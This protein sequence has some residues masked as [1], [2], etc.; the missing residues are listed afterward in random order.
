MRLSNLK[1]NVNDLHGVGKNTSQL[2]SKLGIINIGELLTYF[3]RAYEDR[4]TKRSFNQLETGKAINTQITVTGKEFFG[5]GKKRTLKI[6]VTDDT[7]TASLV[8]FG[9]SFLD[10]QIHIDEQY[11]LYGQFTIKYGELQCSSFEL[12]P[13]TD[14]P[15]NFGKILPLYSLS[16]GLSQKTLRKLVKQA[17]DLY[18]KSLEEELPQ[19]ILSKNNLLNNSIALKYIHFPNNWQQYEQARNSLAYLEL[20]NIQ[21]KAALDRFNRRNLKQKAIKSKNKLQEQLIDSL[22]F[23]LTPDQSQAIQDINNDIST[24]HPMYRLIQGEVGSGKT[25]VAFL[26]ALNA[27]EQGYQVAFMAPTELLAKQHGENASQLLMPLG[28]RIAFMS[29]KLKIKQRSILLEKLKSGEIDLLIGTHALFSSDVQFKSLRLVIVDE[30]HR[31]GVEQRKELAAKGHNP[32]VLL[33]TATPIPRS[34]AL[35]A[36][37]NLDISTIQTMPMGRKRIETHLSKQDSEQKVYDFIKKEL[38]SGH[39][40]YFVYPLIDQS[41]KLD[42]LDAESM[43]IKLQSEFAP[44]HCGLIHSKIQEDLKTQTMKEF[45]ENKIQIL[46]ATSVV[47]VGVDVPNATCIV[48]VHA[49]RFGLSTLHQLRGRVGRS[50]LQSYA[51]L[52]YSTP[53]SEEAKQRLKIMKETNDG[54]RISQ[55]DMAIRGPGDIT[56]VRQSGFMNFVI[57]DITVDGD[58]LIKARDDAN[59]I[60]KEDPDLENPD[61]YCLKWIQ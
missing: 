22:P 49:E 36:F 45:Q 24:P 42:L 35:T 7:G 27:I 31:F 59:S 34:L 5:F 38:A 55:E 15:K 16:E 51:F 46:V 57:A 29:G 17:L 1:I 53:L 21:L 6:F 37:G 8:C 25:L 60:I 14:K 23:S 20:F 28:I 32:D 47:E 11:Y 9:R 3:P 41:E 33:M 2:L 13:V 40:A 10:K 43:Y 12:E 48:I 56:G 61:N 50:E 52:I 30:Q 26:S 39:Q 54:F 4:Q 44:Y 18:G 19:S 58:L